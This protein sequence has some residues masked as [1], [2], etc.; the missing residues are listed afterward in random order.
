MNIQFDM[1]DKES[2]VTSDP[3]L[4]RYMIFVLG[5]H[6]SG[7]SALAGVLSRLGC[8]LPADLMAASE[9]NCKGYFESKTT[10]EFNDCILKDAGT[11]WRDW[12]RMNSDWFTSPV[13]Q[14]LLS[15]ASGLLTQEFGGAPLSIFKDPRVCRMVPF[16]VAAAKMAGFRP[17]PVLTHRNPLEVAKSLS[18]RDG[19][20][21]A[22]GLL[23]WLRHVLSAEAATRGQPRFFTSYEQILQN[24]PAQISRLQ[25]NLN[26]MLPR[27][28]ERSSAQ[29][30]DFLS[31]GL[32]HFT[33][34][35]EKVTDN[36]TLSKWVRDAY[37]ILERWAVSGEAKADYKTLDGI[38]ADFDAAAPI[39][40]QVVDVA[41]RRSSSLNAQVAQLQSKLDAVGVELGKRDTE[42]MLLK[43]DIEARNAEGEQLRQELDRVRGVVSQVE[44]TLAQCRLE[45]EQAH[46]R[47][48]HAELSAAEK[49]KDIN[50]LVSF[51]AE[52]IIELADMARL[53]E[54]GDDQLGIKNVEIER[55]QAHIASLERELDF[56]RKGFLVRLIKPVRRWANILRG[57]G[58]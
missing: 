36:H 55:L 53:I 38:L 23:L 14:S 43:R 51:K 5:M 21:P 25:E 46:M 49:D 17:M 47:A 20:D 37:S 26:I 29:V 18:K 56:V 3:E 52:K 9:D 42:R 58:R 48:T 34:L 31:K 10:Q 57:S 28:D 32:R 33:E 27:F 45:V 2:G 16:W 13:G 50:E 30:E 40:S 22:E 12:R 7:T 1:N 11:S 4:K 15:Q 39:F 8:T 19:M 41:S 6:R 35:P 54:Q 24:W 44:S